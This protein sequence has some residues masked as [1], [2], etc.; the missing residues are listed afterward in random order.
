MHQYIIDNKLIINAKKKPKNHGVYKY[1]A[2]V[3]NNG[4]IPDILLNNC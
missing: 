1:I 4:K 3:W 2:I